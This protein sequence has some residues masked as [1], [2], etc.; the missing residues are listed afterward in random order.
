[1][2]EFTFLLSISKQGSKTKSTKQRQVKQLK[3]G[4]KNKVPAKNGSAWK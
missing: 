1:M 4:V 2:K 3:D